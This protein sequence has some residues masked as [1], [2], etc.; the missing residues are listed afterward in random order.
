MDKRNDTAVTREF[1]GD[2]EEILA[3]LDDVLSSSSFANSD[4]LKNFLDYVVRES[5][6]GRADA[7]KGKTIALDVYGRSAATDGDPENVVRVDARR[8]RR[9]LSDYY[10]GEGSTARIRIHIDSGGYAPRFEARPDTPSESVQDAEPEL[11]ERSTTKSSRARRP[12]VAGLVVLLF[13]GAALAGAAYL[14]LLPDAMEQAEDTSRKS[15]ERQALL[16]KSPAALQAVNMVEQA[17]TLMFPLFDLERQK[18]SLGFYQQAI[19]LDPGYFGGY[20]GAAHTLGTLA[21]LAPDG[22]QKTDLQTQARQMAAKAIELA[23]T[24]PWSQSAASWVKAATGEYDQAVDYSARAHALAPDNRNILEIYAAVALQ[25]G[26]FELGRKLVEPVAT[27]L[28][29]DPRS[30]IQNIYASA[31]FFLGQYRKSL[32][33]IQTSL[34]A[35]GP[36]SP[37]MVALQAAASHAL[38]DTKLA[39]KY[40]TDLT[41]AWPKVP[42]DAFLRRSLRH[43][44]HADQVIWRLEDAGWVSP[45]QSAAAD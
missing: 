2:S 40:V 21:L 20:T 36:I 10:A 4:R 19:K 35:G 13:A 30:G 6:D 37:A 44:E 31:L 32:E 16:E 18:L 17:R 9:R 45:T 24:E 42:I 41:T 3:A 29:G 14:F 27:D 34:E 43:Q 38:G 26:E 11:G 22:P 7:I 15:I 1:H 5:V 8:L 39:R 23:P 25:N 28:P 12:I 33:V